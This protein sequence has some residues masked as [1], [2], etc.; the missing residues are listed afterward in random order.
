MSPITDSGGGGGNGNG[1]RNGGGGH[2]GL[3]AGVSDRLIR[4]LPPAMTLLVV[5]N[6]VFIGLTA[7]IFQHNMTARNEMLQRII[8]S[9]LTREG[10]S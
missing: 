10:R 8:K 1:G 6:I 4:A 2:G 7:Y 3:I 5:L 9:C